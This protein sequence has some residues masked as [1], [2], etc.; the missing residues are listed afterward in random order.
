MEW[1]KTTKEKFGRMISRMPLFHRGIAQISA[2]KKAEENAQRRSSR[3]LS[4]L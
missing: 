2:S 1:E 4:C 3:L